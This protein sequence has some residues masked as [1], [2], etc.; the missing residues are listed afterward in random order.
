[1][2]WQIQLHHFKEAQAVPLPGH[3]TGSGFKTIGEYVESVEEYLVKNDVE[4]P[5]LVGHS[6]GGAI[7]IEHALRHLDLKGL[8]LVG[9]GA[10]LKVRQDLMKMILENYEDASKSIARLSVSP[11]CDAVVTERIASEMLK[12][13]AEVTF[14][15]FEACNHFDR[16]NDVEKIRS[17]TLVI[18]GSDDQLT[19]P[20]YSQYLHQK[21]RRS[22]L[23]IIRGAGHSVM[24]EKPREFNLML[25]SF[26]A[27]L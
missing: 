4:N 17:Q 8:V 25:E 3:P 21:I 13:R 6:M 15:D 10:R 1:M 27:S 26:A 18:C 11:S 2:S 12:V 16:M 24:L 14:G 7:A 19:P 5:V 22:Q 9:T 23:H 20:E